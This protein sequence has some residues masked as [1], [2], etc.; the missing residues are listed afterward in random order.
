MPYV[1]PTREPDAALMRDLP[2]GWMPPTAP[3]ASDPDEPTRKHVWKRVLVLTA[4]GALLVAV[5]VSD[6]L[7]AGLLRLL[8]TVEPVI[9]HH[10]VLGAV[11]FVA[12]AAVSAMLAFFSTAVLVPVAVEAWGVPL[13]MGLLWTGW[14]LG[15]V[16][17]Y[18]IGRY[19]GRPVVRRFASDAVLARYED[20]ISAHAPFGVVLLFLLVL[21]S[22][23]PGYVLGLARYGLGRFA[24]ALALAE[25]PYAVLTVYV[26]TSLVERRLA[27]L[28]AAGAA[29][30]LL[31]GVAFAFLRKRLHP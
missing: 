2:D 5:V 19:L 23:V 12:A 13:T 28:L 8:G 26:G 1:R 31:I 29:T 16:G 11:A 4:L 7:H 21:Q 3:P 10:P 27:L 6:D 20:R 18:A 22:E 15:G 25:V 30:L 24:L 9:A 14:M 17:A